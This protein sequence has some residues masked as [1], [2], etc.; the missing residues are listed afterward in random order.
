VCSWAVVHL[1]IPPAQEPKW[2]TFQRK[3]K[4]M[5]ITLI[6]PELVTGIALEQFRQ[7]RRLTPL[8]RARIDDWQPIHSF[9]A[10]MGGF[11]LLGDDRRIKTLDPKDNPE[12]FRDMLRRYHF[13]LPSA[14]ELEDKSKADAFVKGFAV[15]QSS[16]LVGQCIARACY[17]LP[18]SELELSTCAF[19]ACTIIS[20]TFW[21]HKPLDVA[22]A[23]LLRSPASEPSRATRPDGAAAGAASAAGAAAA[24]VANP[25]AQQVYQPP[26]AICYEEPRRISNFRSFF[27]R[28]FV[29]NSDI[30]DTSGIDYDDDDDQ[31]APSAANDQA[32]PS[33][34]DDQAAPSTADDSDYLIGCQGLDET[35]VYAVVVGLVFGA[36]HLAA[37]D[38]SFPSKVE[39]IAWRVSSLVITLLAPASFLSLGVFYCYSFMECLVNDCVQ[40]VNE[41]PW[42]MLT[43]VFL[44]FYLIAR[45][46]LI[47][48]IF[49]CFRSM[50]A[51]MYVTITWLQYVPHF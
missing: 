46:V 3:A 51:D 47:A 41:R 25:Q 49:S 38:F 32:A 22:S 16:W 36:I 14:E 26:K 33:A 30:F 15:L 7:V 35:I 29:D 23:T 43:S 10:I 48:L 1:N 45:F 6:A 18:L 50:P 12:S 39:R 34:A 19:V 13:F 27:H 8:M 21:W 37:W 9:Y 17:G 31:A 4:W 24:V 11:R 42:V 2:K 5:C 20:Y 44:V 40:Q 28:D